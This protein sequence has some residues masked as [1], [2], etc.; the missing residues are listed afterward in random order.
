MLERRR[1]VG[2]YCETD[3][4][5][6][7]C[8]GC[9]GSSVSFPVAWDSGLTF[10]GLLGSSVKEGQPIS[11]YQSIESHQYYGLRGVNLELMPSPL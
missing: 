11:E 9:F 3:E 7:K 5:N 6:Y 1:G 4:L 8:L 2:A 10:S